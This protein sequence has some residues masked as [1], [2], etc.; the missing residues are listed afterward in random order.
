MEIFGVVTGIVVDVSLL[1]EF[2]LLLRSLWHWVGFASIFS[3][4]LSSHY[5]HYQEEYRL[6]KT[7]YGVNCHGRVLVVTSGSMLVAD[8]GGVIGDYYL[9]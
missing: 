2:L 8:T 7:Y 9:V 3:L 1:Q 6:L 4:K 5:F